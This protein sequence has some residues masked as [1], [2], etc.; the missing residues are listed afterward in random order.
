MYKF[1]K[2]I[3]NYEYW[4][5][6]PYRRVNIKKFPGIYKKIT[7]LD[8]PNNWK[9][10]NLAYITKA[11]LRKLV[12]LGFHPTENISNDEYSYVGI[13]LP[14][15]KNG[16]MLNGLKIAFKTRN[17]AG[18]IKWID[19]TLPHGKYW[20]GAKFVPSGALQSKAN[21]CLVDNLTDYFKLV[22]WIQCKRGIGIKKP[23]IIYIEKD[24]TDVIDILRKTCYRF[25]T[26]IDLTHL[27]V[28]RTISEMGS[29]EVRKLHVKRVVWFDNYIMDQCHSFLQFQDTLT[30]LG[31]C[32][33]L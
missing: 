17:K 25:D 13:A 32:Q 8:L 16:L 22:G 30:W 7:G 10:P 1:R 18:F 20:E 27:D 12:S 5:D 19:Y 28:Y 26:I 9:E 15:V 24:P 6:Y 11:K 4:V 23:I 14:Q 29:R 2:E 3:T 33:K 31:R 21:I